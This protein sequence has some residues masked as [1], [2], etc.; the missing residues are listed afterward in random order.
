MKVRWRQTPGEWYAAEVASCQDLLRKRCGAA[1]AEALQAL[2][3]GGAKRGGNQ[4]AAKKRTT[5]NEQRSAAKAALA[6]A[7]QQAIVEG[8]ARDGEGLL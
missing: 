2:A 3:N 5:L 8:H 1:G 4:N 7:K 6:Q